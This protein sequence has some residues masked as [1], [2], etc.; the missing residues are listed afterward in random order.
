MNLN[1]LKSGVGLICLSAGLV[2]VLTGC[3][4]T[5][6]SDPNALAP[7]KPP[8]TVNNVVPKKGEAKV[9]AVKRAFS[10]SMPR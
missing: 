5:P 7:A 3:S 1:T 2:L 9:M 8:P 6:A 10:N 4:G